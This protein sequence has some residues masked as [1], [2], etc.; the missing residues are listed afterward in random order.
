LSELVIERWSECNIFDLV[1]LNYPNQ[2]NL[3]EL[4]GEV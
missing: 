1:K 3:V 2:L 4:L